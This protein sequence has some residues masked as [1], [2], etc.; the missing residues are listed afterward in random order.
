MKIKDKT[1]SLERSLYNIKYSELTNVKFEGKED[2]ESPL[3]ECEN[4][5]LKNCSF[6]LRYPLW[7]N[8][9]L[10]VKKTTFTELCRAPLWY[11]KNIAF[12]SCILKGVKAF[13][14]CSNISIIDSNIES[15]ELMWNSNKILIKK[16]KISGE[17]AFLNCH[18]LSLSKV[19]FNGKY[20]FQYVTNLTIENCIINTKDA[21]WHAKHVIVKDSLIKGEYLGW[22]SEDITFINCEIESHQPL[23]YVKDLKIINCKMPKCD[24][25]FEYSTIDATIKGKIDSIKNPLKGNIQVDSINELIR[26]DDKY[27]SKARVIIKGE[28]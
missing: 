28:K 23:C 13:R 6:S 14:E 17:Y 19:E 9:G 16:S 15:Q 21:F 12:E 10:I 18:D 11:S 24:L 1:Y 22:Y 26:E 7:H 27:P 8:D 2:G 4:I 20:S 5:T 25:A 3:K